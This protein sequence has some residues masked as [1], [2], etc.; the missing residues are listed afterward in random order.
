[1]DTL[2]PNLQPHSEPISARD[3]LD[4]SLD[5]SVDSILGVL[6][7]DPA[8]GPQPDTFT[9][10]TD[11]LNS[12]PTLD[13]TSLQQDLSTAST[14]SSYSSSDFDRDPIVQ[15]ISTMSD[16][17]MSTMSEVLD[18]PELIELF[19]MGW[20][21]AAPTV[22]MTPVPDATSSL[23]DACTL[24]PITTAPKLEPLAVPSTPPAVKRTTTRTTSS[25]R[26]RACKTRFRRRPRACELPAA[27]LQH[28]R[29]L[30]REAAARR[31]A[32]WIE[33]QA[34]LNKAMAASKQHSKQLAQE[35][36]KLAKDLR[37]L[38]DVVFHRHHQ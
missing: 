5:S 4:L 19:S 34:E 31:R 14:P 10:W 22:D 23:T 15:D 24:S 11:A 37:I 9:S 33:E 26:K 17:D 20:D 8:D 16:Q 12:L 38:T 28:Q 13:F 18:D 1:M 3:S 6:T 7:P 30:A 27:E 29:K 25:G 35:H 36:Q 32:R 2:L 21:V